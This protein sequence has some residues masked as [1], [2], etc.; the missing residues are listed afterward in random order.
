MILTDI[1]SL[2]EGDNL[3]FDISSDKK[4]TEKVTFVE[5]NTLRVPS[6]IHTLQ[7]KTLFKFIYKLDIEPRALYFLNDEENGYRYYLKDVSLEKIKDISI[8]ELPTKTEDDII[9]ERFKDLHVYGASKLEKNMINHP[10]HYGGENNT[11][12]A[13]KVIE[14]WSLDFCLGNVIKYVSRSGKKENESELRDLK[15]AL[16]YLERKISSLENK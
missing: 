6:I 11:Y 10:V 4:I 14:A 1:M 8:T 3:I 13:I 2:K 9:K 5:F 15:K 16:W 12:E 7:E